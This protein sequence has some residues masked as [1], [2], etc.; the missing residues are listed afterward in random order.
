M[1]HC[2]ALMLVSAGVDIGQHV[3][4]H[5]VVVGRVK[6]IGVER[7]GIGLCSYSF[8]GCGK[9]RSVLLAYIAI[10]GML[11]ELLEAWASKCATRLQYESPRLA[12]GTCWQQLMQGIDR[13]ELVGG[14]RLSVLSTLATPEHAA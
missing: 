5:E 9:Q 3:D 12:L 1:S 7:M 10:A 11:S 13:A 4:M 14:N 6:R 8:G 2:W